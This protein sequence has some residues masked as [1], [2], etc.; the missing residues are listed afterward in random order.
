MLPASVIRW[1]QGTSSIGV[2][3]DVHRGMLLELLSV[4]FGPFGRAEEHGLFAV[5]GAVDDRALRFPALF[6]QQGERSSLFQQCYLSRNGIFGSVHP[7]IMMIAAD[8][9]RVWIA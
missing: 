7:G 6:E 8:N 4:V 5:P 1:R 9:P 3:V 2:A